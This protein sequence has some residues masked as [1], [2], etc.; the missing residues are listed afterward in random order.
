MIGESAVTFVALLELF[1]GFG[2]SELF[3]PIASPTLSAA[4]ASLPAEPGDYAD[5]AENAASAL[6]MDADTRDQ[7]TFQR[8]GDVLRALLYYDGRTLEACLR[9]AQLAY[10]HPEV[11]VAGINALAAIANYIRSGGVTQPSSMA[12]RV[13]LERYMTHPALFHN[14]RE[15][16]NLL[17]KRYGMP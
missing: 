11:E 15:C 14:A 9:V 2:K 7:D 10:E 16:R 6:L 17:M 4:I 8:F 5:A 1:S 13:T 3:A 12:L